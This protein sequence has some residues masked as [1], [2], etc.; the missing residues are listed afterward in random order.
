MKYLLGDGVITSPKMKGVRICMLCSF[1]SDFGMNTSINSPLKFQLFK[2]S[3]QFVNECR[4]K[5]KDGRRACVTTKN[6]AHQNNDL[7]SGVVILYRTRLVFVKHGCPRRQQS[8]NMAKISKSY[9]LT[10]PHPRGM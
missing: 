3:A 10:P 8:H 4:R 5:W 9:I 2:F 7:G 6:D 1:H